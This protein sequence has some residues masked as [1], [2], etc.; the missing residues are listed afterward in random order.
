MMNFYIKSF[1]ALSG[2]EVYEILKARST[3]FMMEQEIR[4]L[5]MDDIDYRSLHC[6][7]MEEDKVVA[8]LRAFAD[9]AQ[10]HTFQIGRV[11]TTRRGNGLGRALM[12]QSLDALKE[13]LDCRKVLIHSQT[14]AAGFYEKLGFS[15]I[16]EEFTEADIPHITMEYSFK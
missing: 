1:D 15:P 6:F 12:E 8:Y 7:L 2:A 4:Y 5:D 9:P 16:G 13:Q 10:P 11:L 3:V 14:H